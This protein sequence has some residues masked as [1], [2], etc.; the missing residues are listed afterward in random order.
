MHE[1]S[2][3]TQKHRHT[4]RQKIRETISVWARGEVENTRLEAKAK[5]TKKSEAK[6]KDQGHRCKCS[7]KKKKKERSAE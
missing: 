2:S 7:Q 1:N 3:S 5:Y 6:A 4:K